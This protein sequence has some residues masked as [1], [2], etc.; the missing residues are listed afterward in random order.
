VSLQR[1]LG[2]G[3]ASGQF[4]DEVAMGNIL[5]Q[6]ARTSRRDL[7]MYALEVDS[8]HGMVEAVGVYRQL[9]EPRRSHS[10]RTLGPFDWQRPPLIRRYEL[11]TS[12]YV[13]FRP[14]DDA[15]EVRRLTNTDLVDDRIAETQTIRAWLSRAGTQDGFE[16]VYSGSLRLARIVDVDAA[17]R[18]FG[19]LFSHHRW[20]ETFETENRQ[21]GWCLKRIWSTS[22]RARPWAH[23]A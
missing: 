22:A 2:V 3:L 8:A 9:V 20:H 11:L 7:S 13:L 10:F 12:D 5:T 19:E 15:S 23:A 21:P 17:D 1:F 6:A 14:I 18:S 16:I 4:H